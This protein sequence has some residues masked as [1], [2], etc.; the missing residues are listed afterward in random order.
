MNDGS[1]DHS[2]AS[3][4]LAPSY[5]VARSRFLAAA[6][7]AGATVTAF[8]H[9]DRRGPDGE[10]LAIDVAELGSEDAPAALLVV[11][12]THGV[13]GYAGSAL[14]HHWLDRLVTAPVPDGLRLILVH[15]FNPYGFAWSRRTNEDNVDL[16]RN[17]IDWEA[18]VPA[19]PGY[20]QLAELLVPEAWHDEAVRAATTAA[21]LDA[22]GR[23]GLEELQRV[24]TGGQYH[25]P[26]GLFYGG[27][28]PVWSHRWL[29]AE[30]ERL[31][32]PATQVGIVDLH[33]GLGPW[34]SGEL[35]VHEGRGDP[36]YERAERWWGDVRSM[37]DGESVS[38]ELSGDWLGRIGQ[39]L[40]AVELT[41][42]ALEFGTVD[43]VAVLQALRGE[44]WLHRHDE[45]EAE[46]GAAIRSD[47]R[48]VF[49]DE[50]PRW[51]AA[52]RARF[53][54]VV[55]AAID[56]LVGAADGA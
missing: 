56:Q 24:I 14:Q 9:R 35:I 48:A 25:H 49:A 3:A 53:D 28:G 4:A 37:R 51:L 18:P 22:A 30:A 12:A 44:A 19:N 27:R 23:L 5:R 46:L 32:E 13:E 7:A 33:T 38:A 45:R 8:A 39:L 50:D 1:S 16:N 47:V 21:L 41:A 34:G 42:A 11:S 36:V 40:P 55:A 52:L 43:G 54:E 17:F 6:E 20:D 29:V 26:G 2:R 31:V 10:E 15:G